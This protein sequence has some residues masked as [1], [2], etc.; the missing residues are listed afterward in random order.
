MA[1]SAYLRG[2]RTSEDRGI[3]RPGL[4][5]PPPALH[6][7]NIG[8]QHVVNEGSGAFGTLGERKLKWTCDESIT[9]IPSG[10]LRFLPST[11]GV[12][13]VPPTILTI[14]TRPHPVEVSGLR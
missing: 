3:P 4:G 7:W 11:C 9:V 1:S 5:Y 8:L 14:E 6:V 12:C 10:K 13:G 2:K